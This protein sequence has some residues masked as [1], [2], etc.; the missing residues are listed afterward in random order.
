[1]GSA[2]GT[3]GTLAA[4]TWFFA[5][6]YFTSGIGE[7]TPSPVS[8]GTAVSST[9]HVPTPTLTGIPAGVATV[10][11][12]GAPQDAAGETIGPL[13]YM[14][15]ATVTANAT[16]TQNLL[17]PPAAGAA[18]APTVNTLVAAQ[19]GSQVAKALLVYASWTDS[20]GNIT[21]TG[22]WGAT[23]PSCPV[24]IGGGAIYLAQDLPGLDA[25]ALVGMHAALVEGNVYPGPGL[26]RF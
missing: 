6:T 3:D 20:S 25:Q 17:A 24:I 18:Q 23:H 1:M 22:E 14:G 10:K 8:S 16:T 7:T 19:D 12:Y 11:Y 15:S 21:D 2:A 5:Y 13:L 4:L 26:V 9:N